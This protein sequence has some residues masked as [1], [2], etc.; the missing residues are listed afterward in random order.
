MYI[1]EFKMDVSYYNYLVEEVGLQP[2]DRELSSNQHQDIICLTCAHVFNA[3]PKSKVANFKKWGVK[4]CPKCT[5]K[6]RY[7]EINKVN[8][9]KLEEKFELLSDYGI[10]NYIDLTVRNKECGHVFTSRKGN[11]LNR[12]VTCPVCNVERKRARLKANSDEMHKNSIVTKTGFKKYRQL[13]DRATRATYKDHKNKINP[14][15]YPRALAGEEGYHLDHIVSVKFCFQNDI[16]IEICSDYKNLQMIEWKANLTKKSKPVVRF[17]EIFYPYIKS[18]LKI[19]EFIDSIKNQ[20]PLQFVEFKQ[21]GDYTVTL[22]NEEHRFGIVYITFNENVEQHLAS[23]KHYAKFKEF[24]D[25]QSIKVLFI[26]EDEW[27][28]NAKL[29]LQK[30]KHIVRLN[31]ISKVFARKC[32]VK[33][34]SI[35]DKGVFLEQFHIQGSCGSAINLGAYYNDELV[36]VMTFSN[37]RIAMNK[38]D[39][40]NKTQWELVRFATIDKYHIVGIASKLLSHFENNYKWKIIYSFADRRW[41]DGNVYYKL[42][43]SLDRVN[44]PEYFY[45][46][47]GVRKHRYGYRKDVLR[48]K[49]TWQYKSNLTEYQNMLAFGYDRVWDCGTLKFIKK[50]A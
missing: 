31:N 26:F 12:D 29:V 33:E 49:F 20:I 24:C 45:I 38:K 27:K 11:L 13:V 36:A 1:G 23:S 43:F 16:P 21:L 22:F 37:P 17:P 46:I 35:Q 34:I 4:G 18:A 42:G 3:T 2:T 50:K 41:S 19:D 30:I 14:H 8:I 7:D 47:D 15:D 39:V 5:W 32:T 6:G 48:E 10:D 28:H 9:A 40:G 25:Q 44:K